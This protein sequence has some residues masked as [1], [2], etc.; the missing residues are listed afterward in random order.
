LPAEIDGPGGGGGGGP[1]G[2]SSAL[3]I[4]R[5]TSPRVN[6]QFSSAEIVVNPLNGNLGIFWSYTNLGAG[7]AIQTF[8]PIIMAMHEL[9]HVL[10]LDHNSPLINPNNPGAGMND[11]IKV[12]MEN[13]P[14]MRPKLARG[15]HRVNP[16]LGGADRRLDMD[17]LNNAT[18][19]FNTA[20]PTPGAAALMGLGVLCGFR[21]RR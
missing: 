9:G 6:D 15:V 14:V 7:G 19:T 16:M 18:L 21:R 13:G 12:G 3:A 17:D 4:F 10:R 20:V 11:A 2:P 8:D 5:T 1:G